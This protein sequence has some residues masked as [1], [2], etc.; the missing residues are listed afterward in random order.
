[1]NDKLKVIRVGSRKSEV[2]IIYLNLE[3]YLSVPRSYIY[4][5]NYN[6]K[7]FVYRYVY[8]DVSLHG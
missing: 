7:G 5:I 1:M 4:I 6:Q 2:I 8:L 3:L